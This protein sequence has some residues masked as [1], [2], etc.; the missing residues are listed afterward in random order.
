MALKVMVLFSPL[1]GQPCSRQYRVLSTFML[2]PLY[3]LVQTI[4]LASFTVL[5]FFFFFGS[6]MSDSE[7][8]D[9][10]SCICRVM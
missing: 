6:D 4:S 8:E 9:L 5:I 1:E 10:D 2:P 3:Y 7:D